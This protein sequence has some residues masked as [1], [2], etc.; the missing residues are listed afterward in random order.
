M[1]TALRKV[2]VRVIT[3]E[4]DDQSRMGYKLACLTI[5]CPAHSLYIVYLAGLV[6][7]RAR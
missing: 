1:I 4:R 5:P 3:H 2:S 6:G 7:V